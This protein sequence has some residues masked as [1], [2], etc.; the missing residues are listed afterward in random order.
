MHDHL[1]PGSFRCIYSDTDSM[2]LMLSRSKFPET[3]NLKEFYIGLFDDLVREDKRDSW[4][5][6][7]EDWFVTCRKPEIE[8]KPGLMKRK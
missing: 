6:T 2:S 8:K 5:A 3:D 7:W 4:N 1:M